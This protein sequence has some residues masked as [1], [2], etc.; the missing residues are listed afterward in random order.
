MERSGYPRRPRLPKN[1]L[2][3]KRVVGEKGTPRAR[4]RNS[5]PQPHGQLYWIHIK[6]NTS[7][8]QTGAVFKYSNNYGA[9]H[10]YNKLRPLAVAKIQLNEIH[11]TPQ[12]GR[13]QLITPW[14]RL[15][16][17]AVVQ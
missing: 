8:A 16:L 11:T 9:G 17:K 2:K 15:R 7:I 5:G 13:R 14:Y 12:G 1:G 4:R 6:N 10:K 3:R